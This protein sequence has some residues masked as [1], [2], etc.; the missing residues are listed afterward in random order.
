MALNVLAVDG[1]GIRGIIPAT[2]LA[3]MEARAGRPAASM[4]QLVSGT[5]TGGIIAAA[6]TAPGREG[7]P[8]HR[9]AELVELYLEEGPRIFSRSLGRRLLTGW[10]LFDEKY[11]DDALND[12]LRRYLG[13]ARLSEALTPLLITAYEL[14]TRTPHFFKSWRAAEAAE[15]DVALWEAA[16]ATAAAPSYFEPALVRPAGAAAPLS[17]V[18]GGVFAINPAM[19]A[20]A[21]AARLAPGQPVTLVSLGSGRLTR[22]IRHRQAA[23]WG[24]IEWLRPVIDI[25][26]D[27]VA[28]T[29]D[30][31][32]EQVLGPDRYHRFQVTL[33]LASDALDDARPR[34]LALLQEQAAELVSRDSERLDRVVELL[35]A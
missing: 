31:Q 20:Y 17:L 15:R 6:I 7:R 30:Y 11:G 25:V 9:A 29:V 2:V 34:N 22:P 18:D 10:G 27:G 8:R 23:R 33:D 4:F 1:G 16:R 19:C 13:E 3:E 12:I 14:E 26:F 21:E 32:L 28:D 35:A 5:S 24:R